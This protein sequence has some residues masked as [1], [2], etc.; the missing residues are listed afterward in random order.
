MGSI[1]G[2]KKPP[3]P[4]VIAVCISD[5]ELAFKESPALAKHFNVRL[6]S[7]EDGVNINTM[8]MAQGDG[9][10]N[11]KSG[12]P[13]SIPIQVAG[14]LVEF[15]AQDFI[16]ASAAAQVCLNNKR[17]FMD[18]ATL[19][20]PA[21]KVFDAVNNYR[22]VGSAQQIALALE[23][24][25]QIDAMATMGGLSAYLVLHGDLPRDGDAIGAC[26]MFGTWFSNRK[27]SLLKQAKGVK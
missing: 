25:Q 21:Q 7:T 17:K 13:A 23:S 15:P 22:S 5:A 12:V 20:E 6:E 11:M 24:A 14:T 27:K 16:L 9:F 4:N 18:R 19:T 3:L 8:A 10:I 2:G 26:A 1:L